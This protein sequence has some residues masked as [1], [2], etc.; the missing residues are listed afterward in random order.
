[1]KDNTKHIVE[2][3]TTKKGSKVDAVNLDGEELKAILEE[4]LG[5]EFTWSDY[6]WDATANVNGVDVYLKFVESD[7]G[8]SYEIGYHKD[9][10]IHDRSVWKDNSKEAFEADSDALKAE[11]DE[12]GAGDSDF[13]SEDTSS[14]EDDSVESEP[15]DDFGA[16]D[17]F[18][19][20]DTP[21]ESEEELDFDNFG[22]SVKRANERARLAEEKERIAAK[23]KKESEIRGH[24]EDLSSYFENYFPN[25]DP[26]VVGN[27]V[28][29]DNG[30]ADLERKGLSGYSVWVGYQHKGNGAPSKVFEKKMKAFVYAEVIPAFEEF[31]AESGET[32]EN[33]EVIVEDFTAATDM[34]RLYAVTSS[35]KAAVVA[36]EVHESFK[37]YEGNTI[38]ELFEKVGKK[39]LVA[40]YLKE[41]KKAKDADCMIDECNQKRLFCFLKREKIEF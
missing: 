15:T 4:K 40:K 32:F 37:K 33:P 26:H 2:K 21:D 7:N 22:E 3:Q 31:I 29:T 1:M 35:N 30:T 10:S 6:T 9:G 12:Y 5:T 24:F 34:V 25:V 16:E 39:E 17:D 20:D 23:V 13:A 11:L 14:T 19:S 8:N 36:P 41:D 28:F 27:P 18:E 38:S